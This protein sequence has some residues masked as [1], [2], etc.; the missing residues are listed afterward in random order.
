M[1]V[2]SYGILFLPPSSYSVCIYDM[3]QLCMAIFSYVSS[4]DCFIAVV[5][6]SSTWQYKIWKHKFLCPSWTVLI[7]IRSLLKTVWNVI[8]CMLHLWKLSLDVL[9]CWVRCFSMICCVVLVV[10]TCGHHPLAIHSI[11]YIHHPSIHPLLHSHIVIGEKHCTQQTRRLK[12]AWRWWSIHENTYDTVFI[13]DL[14]H[15]NK[16]QLGHRT[17]ILPYFILLCT[18]KYTETVN[19]RHMPEGGLIWLQHFIIKFELGGKNNVPHLNS[20]DTK[21]FYI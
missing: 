12:D 3:F 19:T 11:A 18:W 15:S 7:K 2:F 16:I 14:I 9:G 5:S 21:L 4:S 17:H 13:N 20:C 8:P 10:D 1:Q 6:L